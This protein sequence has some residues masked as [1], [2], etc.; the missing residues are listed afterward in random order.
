MRLTGFQLRATK[1]Q[2]KSARKIQRYYISLKVR[3][4]RAASKHQYTAASRQVLVSRGCT[5]ERRKADQGD[6]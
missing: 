4:V 1:A 2:C 3:P 6:W 5:S